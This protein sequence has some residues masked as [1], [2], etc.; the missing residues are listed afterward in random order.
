MSNNYSL[1][2]D[3]K[4]EQINGENKNK[5]LG[6]N[7]KFDTRPAFMTDGRLMNSSWQPGVENNVSLIKENNITNSWEYRQY[8]IKNANSIREFNHN[9]CCKEMGAKPKQ[10]YFSL[11]GN[12]IK[13]K[14]NTPY[15]YVSPFDKS[16][17]MGYTSSDLKET[18]LSREELNNRKVVLSINQEVLLNTER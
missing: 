18:Y 8:M 1:F 4:Q 13:D 16:N 9:E 10:D 6:Y 14:H 7:N 5:Y 3:Y 17:P 15:T 12:E 2:M 11:L